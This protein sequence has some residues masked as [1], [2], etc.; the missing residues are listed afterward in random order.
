MPDDS[1][2]KNFLADQDEESYNEYED[3]IDDEDL[4]MF[5]GDDSYENY[6]FEDNWN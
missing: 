3:D 1:G 6:G 4:D 2:E 5:S